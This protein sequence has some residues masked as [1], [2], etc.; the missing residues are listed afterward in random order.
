MSPSEA[1]GP[2]S[3]AFLP[4]LNGFER[5][6]Q[7]HEKDP[8]FMQ[9]FGAFLEPLGFEEQMCDDETVPAV[10]EGANRM[11]KAR[12]ESAP[13]GSQ[14]Q[15]RFVVVGPIGYVVDAR[16]RLCAAS[17]I[18]PRK[19][20]HEVIDVEPHEGLVEA[21]LKDPREAALSGAGRSVEKDDVDVVQGAY[22]SR[23]SSDPSWRAL[24]GV[25]DT[26]LTSQRNG[27]N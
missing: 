2:V 18:T 20:V 17:L 5:A 14:T 1:R 13:R 15:W 22:S 8:Q 3:S 10:G 27:M 4:F 11:V 19:H 7:A 26:Q 6:V 24:S 9:Q 25:Y 12:H 21:V 16:L 23:L